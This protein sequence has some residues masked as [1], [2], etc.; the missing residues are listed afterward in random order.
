MKP[1]ALGLVALVTLFGF[2]C[3]ASATGE[4]RGVDDG[5]GADRTTSRLPSGP[6]E[7]PAYEPVEAEKYPNAKR[8]AAQVAQQVTT[9]ARG[10]APADVVA[11]LDGPPSLAKTIEP[12]VQ[13]D[14]RSGGEV[15]Y[16]QLS[17][18]TRTSFG[19][20][21]IVRQTLEAVDGRRRAVTR[22]LDVR[23]RRSD[24]PWQLDTIASVGGMPLTRPPQ[25][26]P[27]EQRVLDDPDITLSDSA[28][29]DIYGGRVDQA[30]LSALAEA[31]ERHPISVGVLIAG[32]P[33]NIWGTG[34]RSA[35]KAGSAA[36]IY[37][38]AGRLVVDQQA[39]GTPAFDVARALTEGGA[40][41]L[42]S[43]WT[44]GIGS[45]TDD[46]HADHIHVQQAAV[47]QR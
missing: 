26:S 41:R 35:H 42:G 5:A 1:A 23:L 32:H 2:G 17:G 22:V 6:I 14:Q 7:F 18:V 40:E 45:F 34:R 9:Y 21:V 30:L 10:S 37:A 25:L 47:R 8:L 28:R 33:R 44:F 4:R 31:A 38:V 19:A 12:L 39:Q 11:A 15:I 29:W 3:G 13:R 16:P 43:P 46:V 36:D 27:A 24:G 20:M